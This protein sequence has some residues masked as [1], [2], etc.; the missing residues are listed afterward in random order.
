MQRRAVIPLLLAAHALDPQCH[1]PLFKAHW[2]GEFGSA[3]VEATGRLPTLNSDPMVHNGLRFCPAYNSEASC[4]SA[5]FEA[6][7]GMHYDY[8]RN[9]IFPSKLVRVIQHRESV[10][11]VMETNEYKEAPDLEK[12]QYAAAVEGFAPVLQPEL[13]AG[14]WSALL[15]YAA[16]MSCFACKP[17]WML[18]VRPHCPPKCNEVVRVQVHPSDC[19]ELWV[20]CERFGFVAKALRQALLDSIL[21]KQ[22]KMPVEDLSMFEGQQ[23]LCSWMHDLVALHPL[24]RP[25]EAEKEATPASG[26]DALSKRLSNRRL[27][28]EIDGDTGLRFFRVM[29]EGRQSGFDVTWSGLVGPSGSAC[30]ASVAGVLLALLWSSCL[31]SSCKAFDDSNALEPADPG[32]ASQPSEAG[33][34]T[35]QVAGD[36][37]RWQ[38]GHV[39]PERRS[40][41]LQRSQERLAEGVISPL[42]MS[43][44]ELVV[45]LRG[46]Q[47]RIRSARTSLVGEVQETE[48]LDWLEDSSLPRATALSRFTGQ[49]AVA[50]GHRAGLASLWRYKAQG[51]PAWTLTTSVKVSHH[52]WESVTLTVLSDDGRLLLAASEAADLLQ[53]LRSHQEVP[54]EGIDFLE[55]GAGCGALACAFAKEPALKRVIASD[56]PDVVPLMSETSKLNGSLTKSFRTLGP[57]RVVVACEVL[58]WGGWDIFEDDTRDQC[59]REGVDEID[60]IWLWLHFSPRSDPPREMQALEMLKEKGVQSFQQMPAAGPPKVG[61]LGIRF[62]NPDLQDQDSAV[63]R[64]K[65]PAE[66]NFTEVTAAS[67]LRLAGEASRYLLVLA[68]QRGGLQGWMA[69]GSG[70]KAL[71]KIQ[72]GSTPV[73]SKLDLAQTSESPPT[74]LLAA[75]DGSGIVTVW[76]LNLNG[77]LASPNNGRWSQAPSRRALPISGLGLLH[78]KPAMASLPQVGILRYGV[79]TPQWLLSVSTE[80]DVYVLDALTGSVLHKVEGLRTDVWA[81]R[82][83]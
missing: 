80:K 34:V 30:S 13:H 82:W 16:G 81:M 68:M 11:Q 9:H 6:V 42:R 39:L 32:E 24:Q 28:S 70:A 22:A 77:E 31:G 74:L 27:Q 59:M 10:M 17:D 15:T 25:T 5:K 53:R 66:G 35:L 43:D 37:I 50:I 3:S 63:T 75:G 12:E 54:T 52:E 67:I 41:D 55:L 23:V 29:H 18:Y 40:R 61:E 49:G 45:V 65:D 79:T 36:G 73:I 56:L 46:L 57:A 62:A 58:Y 2:F 19:D 44:T 64:Y 21:A 69:D 20:S 14:C 47:G 38:I 51:R 4:C 8:F 33:L 48:D 1:N 76:S 83:R 60:V 26:P 78:I 72:R 7:Q 71:W